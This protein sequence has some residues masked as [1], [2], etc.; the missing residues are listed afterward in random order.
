MLR[1]TFDR[2]LCEVFEFPIRQETGWRHK[3][4]PISSDLSLKSYGSKYRSNK[5][6]QRVPTYL[7]MNSSF[8][9]SIPVA[10]CRLPAFD[11][12]IPAVLHRSAKSEKIHL[13]ALTGHKMHT[14]KF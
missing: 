12:N 2:L 6:S 11:V 8:N 3:S 1:Q 4:P 5:G 10:A 13:F 9:A 14:T 7:K